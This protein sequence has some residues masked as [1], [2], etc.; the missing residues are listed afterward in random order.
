MSDLTDANITAKDRF[1]I[2]L[3][4]PKYFLYDYPKLLLRYANI[5]LHA[6]W[7]TV[8]TAIFAEQDPEAALQHELA[9]ADHT[10]L[11]CRGRHVIDIG[12][13]NGDTPIFYALKGHAR[14][15][16]G[17]EARQQC[18]DSA[19]KLIKK[20][21][22]QRKVRMHTVFV[23]GREFDKIAKGVRHGALKIDIEGG[24]RELI[25][26]ASGAALRKFDR[27]YIECHYGYLDIETRLKK[28]G[29]RVTHTAPF[30]TFRGFG[31]PPMIMGD[32]YATRKYG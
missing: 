7:D 12:A 24:E 5:L 30:Y 22:L 18:V 23:T 10:M 4:L 3:T 2:Y 29:F 26:N 27:I 32:L 17:Y 21:G 28:E 8:F 6:N 11:D 13:Y 16:D 31:K 20:Y 19:N 9:S 1:R 15:V 25:M 14:L